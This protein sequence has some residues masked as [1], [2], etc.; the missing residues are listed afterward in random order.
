MLRTGRPHDEPVLRE[1]LRP[2]H[3]WH[4][5]DGPYFPRPTDTEADAFAAAVAAQPPDDA[6]G[7]PPR[8]A[9]VADAATDALLGTVNW[10]WES[11]A[12]Q[13]ARLGIVLYD[14][15]V[16]GR[17]IGRDALAA[18]TDL[19]FAR[20]DW[21]RLDLATWSGN[22]AMTAVARRLGFV[23]E[24]RFRRARVVDGVRYDSVV[25]GVLREEWRAH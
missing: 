4:R 8:R 12:T 5:W 16:R 11:E 7:L 9:V 6:D 24:A 3:D 21:V 18:W 19:L 1:W 20:T 22:H 17:G 23:E 25:H 10:Y 2:H 14:P 15:A 13:W